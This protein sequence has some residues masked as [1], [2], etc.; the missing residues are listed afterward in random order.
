[1]WKGFIID[2]RHEFGESLPQKL[3]GFL[4]FFGFNM[5]KLLAYFTK[6]PKNG[7]ANVLCRLEALP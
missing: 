1:M 7:V 3:Y 4:V 6:L 2:L 5:L